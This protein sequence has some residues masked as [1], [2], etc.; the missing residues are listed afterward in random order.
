MKYTPREQ[1]CW[2]CCW[3]LLRVPGD[4]P[5]Q[6]GTA[7]THLPWDKPITAVSLGLLEAPHPPEALPMSWLLINE[8]SLF[9]LSKDI[10]LAGVGNGTR[11]HL[12]SVSP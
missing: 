7:G 11:E 2:L 6:A 9:P 3:C 10:T 12:G 8:M 5:S 1:L 4:E